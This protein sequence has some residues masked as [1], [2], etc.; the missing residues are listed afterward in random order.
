M[1]RSHS[2]AGH[3]ISRRSSFRGNP[4]TGRTRRKRILISAPAATRRSS[5]RGPPTS[6]TRPRLLRKLPTE[7][8]SG[9]L[10]VFDL[11]FGKFPRV[12][13]GGSAPFRRTRRLSES[14]LTTAASK[15][16]SRFILSPFAIFGSRRDN[17]GGPAPPDGRGKLE[18]PFF[19]ITRLCI[20][21][22][23]SSII[24]YRPRATRASGALRAFR[25]LNA[26]GRVFRSRIPGRFAKIGRT[27]AALEK[28]L[29]VV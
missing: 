15:G 29:P 12:G 17:A 1:L 23:L 24:R 4:L 25:G 26:P 3:R 6:A 19:F 7:A 27:S 16:E 22:R 10:A 11:L 2:G 5:K 28:I 8:L 14:S 20:F 9:G 13:L 18:L 21:L